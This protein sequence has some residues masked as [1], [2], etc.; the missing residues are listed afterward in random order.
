M[1]GPP[2][3]PA[4][5]GQWAFENISGVEMEIIKSF[6]LCFGHISSSGL[7]EIV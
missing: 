7:P 4:M 3:A 6:I 1:G 5:G 2:A